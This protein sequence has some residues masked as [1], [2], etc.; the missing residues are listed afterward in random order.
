MIDGIDALLTD[1]AESAMR[2][3]GTACDITFD[4]PDGAWA[5][6]RTGEGK[7]GR[8]EINFYLYEVREDTGRRQNGMIRLVE[9]ATDPNRLTPLPDDAGGT[10][11]RY[12]AWHQPPRYFR[13][14][15]MVTAWSSDPLQAHRM[16][17]AMLTTLAREESL[18]L[19]VREDGTSP[20]S[21]VWP[22]PSDD[23]TIGQN[24]ARLRP[25]TLL[26]L[27]QP[28]EN[29]SVSE[30]WSA[31]GTAPRPFVDLVVTVALET[32]TV[33]VLDDNRDYPQRLRYGR[34]PH[35]G[36]PGPLPEQREIIPKDRWA[37]GER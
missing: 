8:P 25:L 26:T 22:S 35:T 34:V 32:F 1:K 12:R 30:L 6:Q 7:P 14:S 20:F 36:A 27:A 18:P 3:M 15:Y 5:K 13:L 10:R 33:R 17:E 16:L 2:L 21:P 24:V 31:L 19:Y 37:K 29:R 4:I 23:P 28:P 11:A 9:E